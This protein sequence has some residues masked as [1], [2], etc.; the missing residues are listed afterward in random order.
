MLGTTI[1]SHTCAKKDC[2][3]C[4]LKSFSSAEIGAKFDSKEIQ[5]SSGL[6]RLEQPSNSSQQSAIVAFAPASLG[7]DKSIR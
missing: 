3:Q 2:N 7:S 5:P 4:L 1:H 6:S